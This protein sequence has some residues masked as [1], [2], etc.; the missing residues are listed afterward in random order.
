MWSLGFGVYAILTVDGH[1]LTAVG[2]GGRVTDT[3]HSDATNIAAWE[4]FRLIC[5]NP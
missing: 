1:Y 2:A 5:T 3:I 4:K